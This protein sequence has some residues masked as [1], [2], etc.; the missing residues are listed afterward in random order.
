MRMVF[1]LFSSM[2]TIHTALTIDVSEIKRPKA[3]VIIFQLT[4]LQLGRVA[5]Q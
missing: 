5:Q 3:L 1:M 2:E 4:R